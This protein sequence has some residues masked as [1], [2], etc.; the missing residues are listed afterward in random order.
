MRLEQP[1]G[2]SNQAKGRPAV[3]RVVGELRR[4]RTRIPLLPLLPPS[5]PGAAVKT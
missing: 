1:I 3:R 4:L 5:S 2:V